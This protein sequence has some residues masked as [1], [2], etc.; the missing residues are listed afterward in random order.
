VCNIEAPWKGGLEIR[1]AVKSGTLK[2]ETFAK[3]PE[4][5]LK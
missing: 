1:A 5:A 2:M 4:P 3:P